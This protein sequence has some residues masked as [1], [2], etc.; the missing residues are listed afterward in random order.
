MII[1]L[2]PTYKIFSACIWTRTRTPDE[3]DYSEI[4]NLLPYQFRLIQAKWAELDLNQQSGQ[5]WTWTNRIRRHLIYSQDRYQLRVT[6]PFS[7]VHRVLVSCGHCS[8]PT[9][10]KHPADACY[11]RTVTKWRPGRRDCRTHRPRSLN[12]M[13]IPILLRGLSVR[14]RTRTSTGLPTAFLVQLLYL[15]GY[16]H[17]VPVERWKV[18]GGHL[19]WTDRSEAETSNSQAEA[20]VSKTAVY[21]IPP[22]RHINEKRCHIIAASP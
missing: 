2:F 20:T 11:A 13:H 9:G 1:L 10:A 19:V 15:F 14:K 3:S 22:H 6:C 12:P 7:A 16:T 17:I 18:S 21:S 5:S 4:S 8:A